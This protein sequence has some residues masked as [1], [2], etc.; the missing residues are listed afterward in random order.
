MA[1]LLPPLLG[2]PG[3]TDDRARA[4]A[5]IGRI[6]EA[7]D[8]S[9]RFSGAVLVARG[10]E[11]TFERA[12][13]L[14]DESWRIPNSRDTRFQIGSLTKQ[15]TAALVLELVH[16]GVLSLEVPLARYF[17]EY[18]SDTGSRVTL[19]HLLSHTSGIPD[20]VRRPDIMDVVLHPATPSEVTTKYC[21][22]A[23]EFEPGS[24]FKYS[25]CGYLILGALYERVSGKTYAEGV[26]AL[27]ARAGMHDTGVAGPRDIVPRLATAYVRDGGVQKKAPYIDWSVA[28]ASGAVY[29]TADDLWRWRRAVMEESVLGKGTR[30]EIFAFRPFGYSFGWH[31]GRSDRDHFQQFL[32]SDNDTAQAA[33]SME[34]RMAAHSGDLPGFH[35]CMAVL[36]DG[37]WTVILLDNHD[38]RALPALAAEILREVYG[39]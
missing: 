12:A 33:P 26:A 5:K 28:F 25:N 34:I 30:D 39:T 19:E 17:P 4:A 7:Y 32:A 23:L 37:S 10:N 16:E 35:S 2:L 27:A 8:R 9:G 20:F 15:F 3:C 14:A 11:V 22:E 21:S 13:G 6:V 38:S 1:V 36:L 31:V 18:R 24:R 29:S